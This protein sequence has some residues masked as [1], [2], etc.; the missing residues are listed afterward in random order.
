MDRTQTSPRPAT[1]PDPAAARPRCRCV[2]LGSFTCPRTHPFEA[3]RSQLEAEGY[4]PYRDPIDAEIIARREWFTCVCRRQL[5][6]VGLAR[7]GCY[8]AFAVCA[9]CGHWCEV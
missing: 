1:S 7:P 3:L 2:K 4:R 5:G 6:Y 8:R 9:H